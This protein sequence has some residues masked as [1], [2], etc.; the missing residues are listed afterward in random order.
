[1]AKGK[2]HQMDALGNQVGLIATG[3]QKMIM[4]AIRAFEGNPHDRRTIQPPYGN[5]TNPWWVKLPKNWWLI[6]GAEKASDERHQEID[7]RQNIEKCPPIKSTRRGKNS[8]A[9]PLW[10]H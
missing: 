8:D 7:T 2:A 10:N 9:E 3:G 4:T 1:M 5:N 6:G